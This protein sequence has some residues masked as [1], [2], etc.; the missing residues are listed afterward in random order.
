MLLL[1]TTVWY[2]TDATYAFGSIAYITQKRGREMHVFPFSS[3]NGQLG[4]L[5]IVAS[6]PIFGRPL[7]GNH[8]VGSKKCRI[9]RSRHI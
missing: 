1:G 8:T 4:D 7:R 2:E 6:C 5:C 3:S 9:A